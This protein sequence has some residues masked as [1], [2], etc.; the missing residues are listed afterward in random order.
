MPY[1]PGLR[2]RVRTTIRVKLDAGALPLVRP[3]KMYARYGSGEKC[4]GCGDTLHPAQVEYEMAYKDGRAFRL[5]LG[6][7]GLW[8]AELR[9][10][11]VMDNLGGDSEGSAPRREI[12]GASDSPDTTAARLAAVLRD[13]FPSGYC[14]E[15]LAARL[16]VSVQELRAAAQLLV[17][18]PGFRVMP[19][20]CYTCARIKDDVVALVA[21]TSVDLSRAA[22]ALHGVAPSS[23][24]GRTVVP[25]DVVRALTRWLKEFHFDPTRPIH[26]HEAADGQG[27]TLSQ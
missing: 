20:I 11:G 17:A 10:R 25:E 27:F 22:I 12:H 5:H 7:A 14:V 6:C 13:G 23:L 26:L 18:R 24:T 2:E 19:R 15:C 1:E 3:P 4:D 9:R 8:E 16:D 21:A